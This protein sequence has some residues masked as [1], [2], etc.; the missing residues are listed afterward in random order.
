MSKQ[1]QDLLVEIERQLPHIDSWTFTAPQL[2]E[3][4]AALVPPKPVEHFN[5]FARADRKEPWFWPVD[6]DADERGSEG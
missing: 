2:R 4:I 1:L 3:L 5:M 6:D